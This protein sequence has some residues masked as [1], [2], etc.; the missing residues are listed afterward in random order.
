MTVTVTRPKSAARTRSSPS[1]ARALR[2]RRRRQKTSPSPRSRGGCQPSAS[3]GGR[4]G[5]RIERPRLALRR[6]ARDSPRASF[7][8]ARRAR[9][10]DRPARRAERRR[11]RWPGAP[12]RGTT[13]PSPQCPASTIPPLGRGRGRARTRRPTCTAPRCA[14]PREPSC[15]TGGQ[16]PAP[17]RSALPRRQQP[18]PESHQNLGALSQGISSCVNCH[19]EGPASTANHRR[20]VKSQKTPVCLPVRI[21]ANFA[22]FGVGPKQT[23]R[24]RDCQRGQGGCREVVGRLLGSKEVLQVEVVWCRRFGCHRERRVLRG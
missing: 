19:G 14:N 10:S 11:P 16:S 15:E 18:A 22:I 13:P 12:P 9:R 2:R 3:G 6:A 24:R 8:A 1:R 7:R 23:G 20:T 4:L 17:R 5:R 21:F